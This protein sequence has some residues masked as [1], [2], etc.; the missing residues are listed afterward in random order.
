MFFRLTFFVVFLTSIT[1]AILSQ[2]IEKKR[3]KHFSE[4]HVVKDSIPKRINESSGLIFYRNRLWTMND[5]G[6]GPYIYVM[7]TAGKAI[8]QVITI[9]NAKN[10]DWEEISQDKDYI[11]VGDFGNNYGFRKNLT[12][13][14]V[15]K[16]SIPTHGN[17]N[18]TAEKI[19][20]SYLNM[21]KP[22]KLYKRSAYDM[23]AMISYHDTLVLFS[24]NWEEPY[25]N[26]YFIPSVPGKYQIAPAK[27]I[28]LDGLVTAASLSPDQTKVLLLGYRDY[29]PFVYILNDFSLQ[30]ISLNKPVFTYFT[31]YP[32]YQ[33]EG[34]TFMN[35]H[36]AMISCELNKYRLSSLFRIYFW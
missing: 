10:N 31:S 24:K 22:G 2:N 15:W 14:K 11:Y 34:I 26:I 12:I 33:T 21:P 8:L 18:V 28:H 32:G 6:D 27:T 16:K 23:E 4:P 29:V 20:F 5:S 3:Y 25:C 1:Q 17:A 35:D 9:E 7:D 19:E 30:H 36:E 13:Y